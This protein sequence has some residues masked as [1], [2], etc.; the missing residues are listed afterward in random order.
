[1]FEFVQNIGRCGFTFGVA[2][3]VGGGV[4]LPGIFVGGMGLPGGAECCTCKFT[5]FIIW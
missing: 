3:L 2:E 5:G 1:M 4:A